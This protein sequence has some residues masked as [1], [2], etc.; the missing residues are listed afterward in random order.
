MHIY[1]MH[2]YLWI[3]VQFSEIFSLHV[4]IE[5]DHLKLHEEWNL[6]GPVLTKVQK[7]LFVLN[8]FISSSKL[9]TVHDSRKDHMKISNL[10]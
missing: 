7:G 1:C 5:G 9:H 4:Y 3:Y 10:T 8:S 6:K 2:V